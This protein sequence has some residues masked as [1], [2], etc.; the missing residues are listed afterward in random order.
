[1]TMTPIDSP[2]QSFHA[3]TLSRIRPAEG[4]Q[5]KRRE[6]VKRASASSATSEPCRA[7][8]PVRHHRPGT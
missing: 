5:N 4:H 7:V 1:M 6:A 2:S 8:P 3:A